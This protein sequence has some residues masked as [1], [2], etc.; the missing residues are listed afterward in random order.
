VAAVLEVVCVADGRD[1]GTCGGVADARELH[2]GSAALIV[3]RHLQHVVVVLGDALVEPVDVAQRVAD[4]RVRPAWQILEVDGGLAAHCGRPLREHDAELREQAAD[5]V[6]RGRAL[7]DQALAHT[8]NTQA[9]LLVLALDRNETHVR[10]LHGFADGHR[11]R[12]VVLALFAAQSIRRDLL[13]LYQAH[14]VARLQE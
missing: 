11:V 3:A 1:Q 6:D 5:A 9:R 2:Q 8:V 13:G 7:L 4:G 10:S 12:C 14:G